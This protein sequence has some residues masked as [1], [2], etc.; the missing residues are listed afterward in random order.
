MVRNQVPLM[1]LDIDISSGFYSDIESL[2]PSDL[3]NPPDLNQENFVKLCAVVTKLV[4]DRMDQLDKVHQ[5]IE[6]IRSELAEL[7]S[8]DQVSS[9]VGELQKHVNKLAKI[10]SAYRVEASELNDL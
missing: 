5:E 9:N 7:E 8:A 4:N 6:D 2:K 1:P 3:T 10:I